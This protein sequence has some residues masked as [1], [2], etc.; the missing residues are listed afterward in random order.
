MER[1][2][3]LEHVHTTYKQEKV[4]SWWNEDRIVP[5]IVTTLGSTNIRPP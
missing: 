2:L 4:I 1:G 5:K 3:L